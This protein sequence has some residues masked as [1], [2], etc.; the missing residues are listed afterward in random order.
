MPTLNS[1]QQSHKRRA[2]NFLQWLTNETI[3]IV[4]LTSVCALT[5]QNS[6][7]GV[8]SI[9][10]NYVASKQSDEKLYWNTNTNTIS[11]V[12]VTQ[13][14]INYNLARYGSGSHHH[15]HH[16]QA[17]NQFQQLLD[18]ERSQSGGKYVAAH[19]NNNNNNDNNINDNHNNP[20]AVP[21]NFTS[22]Y[23]IPTPHVLYSLLLI[24]IQIAVN[25]GIAYVFY[26]IFVRRGMKPFFVFID[27]DENGIDDR[28]ENQLHKVI[29]AE[30]ALRNPTNSIGYNH[31][32]F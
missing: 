22:N 16:N 24:A 1:S 10:I 20:A 31:S 7:N 32:N 23:Y 30:T 14:N 25:F 19:C 8:H 29:V 2:D 3:G 18:N 27:D 5:I 17:G 15:R 9:F 11:Y 26:C 6:I 28:T 13:M 21:E 4:I 12:P